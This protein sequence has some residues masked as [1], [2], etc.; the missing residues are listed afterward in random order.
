MNLKELQAKSGV[1]PDGDFGPNTLKA[2]MKYLKMTP[3]RAA[4]FFAQTSHECGGFH[5]F[6]EILNYSEQGLKDTFPKYFKGNEYAD[7][8][9]NAM[10]IANRAYAN[11]IGNGDEASGDGWKYRGR[12]ALQITGKANYKSFA[13]MMGKPEIMTNPD[14]IETD[15][16]FES[17]LVFFDKKGL[18]PICD[19]G[20]G[21]DVIK[22][23]TL[24]IN[25][26]LLGLAD[27]TALTLKFY[28]WVKA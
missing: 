13:D 23:I 20:V 2:A 9:H 17:A 27:R 15:Y 4:H 1:N 22:E 5:Q 25:G 19:R 14:L 10:R 6:H 16:A 11:R 28:D 18:W 12:G 24:K 7:F 3:F 21:A 8:A 26:G